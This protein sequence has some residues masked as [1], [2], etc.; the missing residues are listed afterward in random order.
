MHPCVKIHDTN[1]GEWAAIV[2]RLL[3]Y[4]HQS[5][6]LGATADIQE[7]FLQSLSG[8]FWTLRIHDA[9]CIPRSHL[10][11][12]LIMMKDNCGK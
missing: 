10:N 3:M 11:E 9:T 2:Q 6:A 7:L 1:S 4:G 12:K 8:E 5:A